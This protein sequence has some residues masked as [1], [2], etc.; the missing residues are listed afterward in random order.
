M[1]I[2]ITH[3]WKL[4]TSVIQTF[5]CYTIKWLYTSK[6]SHK[7][8][9]TRIFGLHD[10]YQH[11]KDD[12]KLKIIKIVIWTEPSWQGC[13]FFLVAKFEMVILGEFV[14]NDLDEAKNN[15][16]Q[17]TTQIELKKLT[18]YTNSIEKIEF[19]TPTRIA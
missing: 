4:T 18:Y 16:S 1:K 19:N 12:W 14:R 8:E 7:E 10:Q 15:Q 13:D 17:H 5:A 11:I 2:I 3:F 6:S 9:I